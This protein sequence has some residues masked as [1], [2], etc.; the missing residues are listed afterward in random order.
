MIKMY[1]TLG[2]DYKVSMDDVYN[3]KTALNR[4]GYYD[5]PD[6]GITGYPDD[7]LFEAIRSFQRRENLTVDGVMR[8]DGET[9][10]ALN[11]RLLGHLA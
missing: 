9:N 11:N 7:S 10:V 4:M 3:V 8:P 6:Y 2:R 1:G 5:A